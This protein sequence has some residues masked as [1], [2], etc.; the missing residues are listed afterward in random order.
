MVAPLLLF[1]EPRA[2]IFVLPA[3]P[4]VFA[5][6]VSLAP[7][8]SSRWSLFPPLEVFAFLFLRFPQPSAR[9]PLH[10]D[11]FVLPFQLVQ[12]RQ[13]FLW[14]ARAERGRSVVD[15]DRPVRESR[16]HSTIVGALGSP[17]RGVLYFRSALETREPLRAKRESARVISTRW[18]PNVRCVEIVRE[19]SPLGGSRP[20]LRTARED[21]GAQ[22]SSP[23]WPANG[24]SVLAARSGERTRIR[25]ADY[26]HTTLGIAAIEIVQ[27]RA[28]SSRRRL[29]V[30]RS[31]AII[32]NVRAH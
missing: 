18:G 10:R 23:S 29:L 17:R 24:R 32:G 15:E 19:A 22:A 20:Q 9:E 4:P 16:R 2:R 31:C 6:G 26:L 5:A 21:S 28:V 1:V 30:N 11:V 8:R 3:R 13:E 12:R 25:R 14:I 27:S 7:R